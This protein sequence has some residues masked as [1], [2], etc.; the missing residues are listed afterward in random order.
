MAKDDSLTRRKRVIESQNEQ[1]NS[2]ST[3]VNVAILVGIGVIR[4]CIR[5]IRRQFGIL[6]GRSLNFWHL[7]R[8]TLAK[9][10]N[11]MIE[12]EKKYTSARIE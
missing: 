4:R 7:G 8:S 1:E 11:D 12:E 2:N 9:K 6:V 10:A 5:S 3:R